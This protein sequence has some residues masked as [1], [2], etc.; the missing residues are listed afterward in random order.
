L[1]TDVGESLPRVRIPVPPP[2]YIFIGFQ[3]VALGRI[4]LL[5][6][7]PSYISSIAL[8]FFR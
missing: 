1:K 6:T 2:P 4:F 7:V 5:F 8:S 3:W